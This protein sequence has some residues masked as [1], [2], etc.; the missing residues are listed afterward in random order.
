MLLTTLDHVRFRS[1]RG[2]YGDDP[3][4]NFMALGATAAACSALEQHLQEGDEVLFQGSTST[5]WASMNFSNSLVSHVGRYAGD[6]HIAHLTPAGPRYD[7]LVS[8]VDR[9][10]RVLGVRVDG[11]LRDLEVFRQNCRR[12]SFTAEVIA[13]RRSTMTASELAAERAGVRARLGLQVLAGAPRLLSGYW[14]RRCRPSTFLD[15]AL[16]WA[17]AIALVRRRRG[18]LSPSVAVPFAAYAFNAGR[19]LGARTWLGRSPVPVLRH[20]GWSRDGGL[21][22]PDLGIFRLL[23]HGGMVITPAGAV[24]VEPLGTAEILAEFP[25]FSLLSALAG[26][27]ED[28]L[29]GAPC[30]TSEEKG[31][32]L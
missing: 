19:Y 18:R 4:R 15:A 1:G 11:E 21:T 17:A 7:P 26:A 3:A 13:G 27:R 30:R 16:C 9:G 32:E 20:H 24:R 5:A 10:S 22:A 8:L 28:E 12:V 29:S 2:R 6:G 23:A 14:F 31:T 25:T